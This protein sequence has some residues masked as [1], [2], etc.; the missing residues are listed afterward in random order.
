MIKRRGTI[1]KEDDM[2]HV[3]RDNPTNLLMIDLSEALTR[4]DING[5][6]KIVLSMEDHERL[7]QRLIGEAAS[8][9][10][11]QGEVFHFM[12]VP[13][14]A[15]DGDHDRT[16]QQLKHLAHPLSE[17]IPDKTR[18]DLMIRLIGQL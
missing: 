12:G 11:R 9:K 1:I 5:S 18:M 6:A 3:K 7:R 13:F 15:L 2:A 14:L 17:G 16:V 4:L 8:L 10:L